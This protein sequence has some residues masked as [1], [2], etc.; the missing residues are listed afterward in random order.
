MLLEHWRHRP[1]IHISSCWFA[2]G[3]LNS[4][5]LSHCYNATSHLHLTEQGILDSRGLSPIKTNTFYQ[6][7]LAKVDFRVAVFTWSSLYVAVPKGSQKQFSISSLWEFSNTDYYAYLA[8]IG[9]L[10]RYPLLNIAELQA[11]PIYLWKLTTRIPSR[12]S[13]LGFESF[14]L[15]CTRYEIMRIIHFMELDFDIAPS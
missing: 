14:G 4:H 5:A 6:F 10:P 3:F 9:T 1:T 2:G 12:S 8:M 15:L 13:R 7:I 11:K